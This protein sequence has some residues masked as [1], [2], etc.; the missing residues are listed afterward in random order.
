[1]S[2]IKQSSRKIRHG[3]FIA[4]ALGVLV[5]SV[6]IGAAAQA[7][8]CLD[9]GGGG[10]DGGG[11]GG[12]A[13]P[14]N[15]PP[16]PFIFQ[17]PLTQVPL[18]VEGAD[19]TAWYSCRQLA[20]VWVGPSDDVTQGTTLYPTGVVVPGTKASFAF[21]NPAGQLVASHITKPAR[22]NCVIHH[23]PEAMSTAGLTPGYYFVYASYWSM[24]P[25][26]VVPPDSF[27]GFA[28]S[29]IAR[30]IMVIRIR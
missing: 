5:G 27:N 12:A 13:P 28:A 2:I 6:S 7:L 30:Y 1:M 16:P 15:P 9:C 8:P 29:Y 23:E 3:V 26:G 24:S 21:Y 18:Q 25:S 4:L 19:P 22:D 17:A 14:V 20:H 10:G 11:G